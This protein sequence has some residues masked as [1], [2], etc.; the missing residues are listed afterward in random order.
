MVRHTNS[1]VL[2]LVA[3]AVG[4]VSVAWLGAQEAAE[5]TPRWLHIQI[6]AEGEDDGTRPTALN[7][8]LKAVGLLIAM[9][10]DKIISSD[11]RL[12]VAEEHGVS[13]SDIRTMWQEVMAA[14]D[15]EFATF[16]RADRT[17]AVARVGDRVEVRVT[18]D[19]E[20][21]R[22]DLPVVVIGA[23]LSGDGETLNLVAGIDQLSGLQGDIVRATDATQQIRVWVDQMAEQ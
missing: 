2:A 20:N 22:L 5:E 7:F 19:G 13:V 10:P 18:G 14:G 1:R 4:A 12:T 23:L 6:E 15:S 16:Q 9:V 8:P 17:F 21:M 11:G 3:V